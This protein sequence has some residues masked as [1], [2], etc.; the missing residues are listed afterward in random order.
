MVKT[1]N[2][3][4]AI[5]CIFGDAATVIN[6]DCGV[7]IYLEIFLFCLS[8]VQPWDIWQ[9]CAA[10]GGEIGCNWLEWFARGKEFDGKIFEKCQI[11]PHTLPP[12]PPRRLNIDRCI[13]DKFPSSVHTTHLD[14][15]CVHVAWR[16]GMTIVCVVVVV[17]LLLLLLLLYIYIYIFFYLNCC[18]PSH[19]RFPQKISNFWKV[20]GAAFIPHAPARTPLVL[21]Q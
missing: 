16:L 12:P 6:K 20:G 13:I 5:T 10:R 3:G 19:E 21:T 7:L 4:S 8:W 2:C 9:Q 15:T 1:Y 18:F 17:V 11:P 14:L